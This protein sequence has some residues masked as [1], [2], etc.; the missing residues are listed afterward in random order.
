MCVCMLS[1]VR[2]FATLWTV[3]CQAPSVYAILQA[4]ILGGGWPCP[5]PRDLSDPGIEPTSPTS[6]A[7]MVDCLSLSHPG[8]PYV[9][10][11][12]SKFKLMENGN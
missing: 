9:Y 2:L 4:R 11:I 5:P 8:K 10:L 12:N 6:S 1:Q 3:A 7:L